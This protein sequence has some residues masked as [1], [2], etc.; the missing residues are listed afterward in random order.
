MENAFSGKQLDGVRKETHVVSVMIPRL[1]TDAIRDKKDNRPLLHQ[2]RRHRLTGKNSIKKVQA[3]EEKVP[4]GK[5]S[6]RYFSR[7]V[8]EPVM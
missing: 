7:K 8:Y 6:C 5:I 1:E 2:K 4:R 3:A